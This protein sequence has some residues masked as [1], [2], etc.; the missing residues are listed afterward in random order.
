M[1]KKDSKLSDGEES[2]NNANDLAFDNPPS[3]YDDDMKKWNEKFS[4]AKNKRAT[5]KNFYKQ[6]GC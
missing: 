6:S 3:F 5:D 2:V 4:T 1:K